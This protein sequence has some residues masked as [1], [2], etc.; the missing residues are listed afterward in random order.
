M[1]AYL[2]ASAVAKLFVEE[3]GSRRMREL[4]QSDVPAST[5]ELTIVELACTLAAA[6]R[7]R[8][9]S[10]EL[11]PSVLD[12]TFVADRVVLL[13]ADTAVVRAAAAVGAER[14]LRALDAIHVASALLLE[15]ADPTLVSWDERQRRAAAAEGLYVYP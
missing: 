13:S 5:S 3:A 14:G 8:R 7:A 10:I 2:D 6:S 11:V 4:W 12:G 15:D 9:L 1:I